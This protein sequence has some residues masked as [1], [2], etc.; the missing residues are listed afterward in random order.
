VIPTLSDA[1]IEV[2]ETVN[3]VDVAGIVKAVMVGAVV[4]GTGGSVIVVDAFNEFETLFAA[5]LA[6]A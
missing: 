6:Q 2:I 3:E 4:S 5:S 1:T